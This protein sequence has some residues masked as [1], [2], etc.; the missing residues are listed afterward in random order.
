[1]LFSNFVIPFVIGVIF[2]FGVLIYKYV[3]WFMALAAESK[4]LVARSLFTT[5]TLKAVVEVLKESLL[6]VSIFRHNVLLGFMHSSLAFGW[7]LLIVV[8]SIEA[9]V[10]L[11]ESSPLYVHIFFKYFHPVATTVTAQVFANIMDALLL[12]VLTGVGLAMYKRL[13]KGSM[14]MRKRSR[15]TLGDK[16]A[17]T[18]LWFIFPLRLLAESTTSG[19][20][21]SGGFMTGTIGELLSYIPHLDAFM[22]FTWWAYS[23][24]LAL[25]FF[26]M[27]FSRYMH[28]FTEIPHI[29]LRYYGVKPTVTESKSDNF[30]VHSCSRCGMCIDT[31]QMQSVLNVNTVQAVYFLRNKRE[32][33]D[34]TEAVDNCLMCGRC[35]NKCPVNVEVNTLRLATKHSM[36]GG[37]ISEGR[38]SYLNTIAGQTLEQE[39]VAYF[40]GCMTHISP[41][42]KKS[43]RQ[44]FTHV[45]EDVWFADENKGVCCGRPLRLAGETEAAE[46]MI[47]YNLN[48]FKQAGVSTLITSCPICLK[49][50]SEDYKL[51]S[52]GI[53][54]K[55]H[56]VYIAELLRDKRLTPLGGDIKVTYHDPCELGRGMGV[57]S[58]PREVIA[59]YAK[60]REMPENRSH[61]LCCGHSLANNS[62]L[63][64]DKAKISQ[65]VLDK[66]PEKVLITACPQ[67]RDAFVANKKGIKVMDLAELVA[68]NL[69]VMP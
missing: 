39:K 22:P 36:R 65:A 15:H 31:C 50:F 27:P 28:I 59:A 45:G 30:Q 9:D 14:G 37:E 43:M 17:L 41:A 68:R 32:G 66:A 58:E 25:F 5:K 56:S 49:T 54:V 6:H 69:N 26:A 60:L 34:N 13:H 51:E 16:L 2:L 1:M 29:F 12:L 18:A 38:Y 62:L 23:L 3:S 44:I 33:H 63:N 19:V 20:Y 4:K 61:A 24:V 48:L 53:K 57:Y 7:F 35:E 42:I 46:K 52:F 55:H 11:G 47:N 8:G 10:V 40:A 64:P 67:C 21:G